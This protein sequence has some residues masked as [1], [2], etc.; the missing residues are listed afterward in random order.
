MTMG[1][2]SNQV[3]AAAVDAHTSGGIWAGMRCNSFTAGHVVALDHSR[4]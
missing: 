3:W 2:S 4:C 1:K